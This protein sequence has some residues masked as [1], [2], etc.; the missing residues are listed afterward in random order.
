MKQKSV[1]I[2]AYIDD[3]PDNIN[4]LAKFR[5]EKKLSSRKKKGRSSKVT[6]KSK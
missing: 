4:W 2:S 6:R 3:D 5:K 1:T